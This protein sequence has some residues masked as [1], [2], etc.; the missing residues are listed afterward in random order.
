MDMEHIFLQFIC[1]SPTKQ[2]SNIQLAYKDRR[3]FQL[4]FCNR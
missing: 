3:E 4:I 2:E 1:T